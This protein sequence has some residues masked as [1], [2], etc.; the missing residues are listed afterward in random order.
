MKRMILMLAILLTGAFQSLAHNPL[1]GTWTY[2]KTDYRDFNEKGTVGKSDL[3]MSAKYVF[4]GD[5]FSTWVKAVFN[6]DFTTRSEQGESTDAVFY[7]EVIASTIGTLSYD[8]STL[9]LTPDPKKKPQLEVNTKIEGVPGGN[10]VKN[11]VVNP[12]KKQ[13]SAELKKAQNYKV[14]SIS[15][16]TLVLENILSDKELKAGKQPERVTLSRR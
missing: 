13:L 7:I 11:M 14:V 10:L 9:T 1:D 6:M 15:E 2:T 5:N 12:L 3:K 4:D 16:T 8:G